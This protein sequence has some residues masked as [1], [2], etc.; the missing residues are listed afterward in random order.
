M[1]I[2]ARAVCALT[3]AALAGNA[4]AQMVAESLSTGAVRFFESSDAREHALPSYAIMQEVE[5][6]PKGK[7]EVGPLHPAFF[8]ATTDKGV[9]QHGARITLTPGTSLYGTGEAAGPLLRNGRRTV[10]WNTDAYGYDD[11]APSLYKSHPWVLAVRPDGTAFGVLAD[12]TYRC[13]ID[14]AAAK[15]DELVFLADGPSFAVV[16]IEGASPAEVVQGLA[17]LTGTMPLPAR[18]TLGYHQCRYSYYPES[19]VREIAKGFR[20]RHIPCDVIW[21]D[22]DYYESF[23]CFTFDRGYFPDPKELNAD[24][25]KDGFHNVWM[26]NPG[27]KSREEP[28]PAE[29][30]AA[31][32]AKEPAELRSARE[33]EKNK[34]RT[35]RDDG[36]KHDVYVKNGAGKVYEG[37]VWPGWCYFPDYTQPAVREWWGPWY[38]PFIDTGITGVWNDM[39][40]P[41]VF[42]VP[43]KTMPLDNQH[44]GDPTLV[45]PN[46]KPQGEGA[47]GDHAR[48]HNVYGLMMVKGTRDGIQAAAPDKRPFVLSRATYIGGQRYHAGW[49]GD[50]SATWYHLENSVPM[51]LNMG[52]S[53]FSFYGPD[54]GGFA[55]DGDGK[56]FERWLGFGS[57]L[58]FCRAHTGKGNIDKEPWAFGAEIEETSRLALQRRYRLM[59]YLYTLFQECSQDGMPVARPLF[60]LDPKDPALRSEDDAFLLGADLMVVPQMVP[61]RTRVPVMP[62]DFARWR[63]LAWLPPA[64]AHNTTKGSDNQNQELPRL[65]LRPGAIL[66]TGPVQEWTTQKPTDPLT[67]I[68]NLD[69]SGAASGAMYEDDGDGYAY[70][71]GNYRLTTFSAKRDGDSVAVTS[72]AQGKRAGVSRAVEVRV[73]LDGREVSKA[74]KAGEPLNVP[75]GR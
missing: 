60:F 68:I 57:L 20:D 46:G 21:F 2:R 39:N 16:I 53:G 7:V 9:V 18:W 48:Y 33:A 63:E 67:L 23:R 35:L 73:L 55:G 43:S 36:L 56:L 6:A 28:S 37:E 14:C 72:T 31:E 30:P 32:R 3:L 8:E 61:D 19:R 58:P 15:P 22:I 64:D 44:A 25:L 11:T 49:S 17:R 5:K 1:M 66:P 75:V 51:T 65:Y 71:Q 26:I 50:N 59:P 29:P 70:Q 40:E 12:T 13:E 24:L 34:F 42:N 62:K 47:Q 45:A 41:A 4:S 74:F 27:I 54:I 10:A 52:L 69:A 38:K